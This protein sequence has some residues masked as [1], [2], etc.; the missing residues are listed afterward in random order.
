[1]GIRR[2]I[3]LLF[4]VCLAVLVSGSTLASDGQTR[5]HV[6]SHEVHSIEPK[7]GISGAYN[8]SDITEIPA[9][10]DV[11]P[12]AADF[13]SHAVGFSDDFSEAA[14]DP[15]WRWVNE[16][17]Q[18][19][20]L[21]DHPGY[22]RVAVHSGPVGEK[23]LL[24]WNPPPGDLTIETRVE[25]RPTRNYQIAGV[26]LFEDAWNYL[27]LGRAY[28]DSPP[29]TCAGNAIYFDRV[30][31]GDL[32]GGAFTTATTEQ[33]EAYLRVVREGTTYSGYY[34]GDGNQWVLIGQ[35]NPGHTLRLSGI[36][37]A[38]GQDLGGADLYADF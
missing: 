28:C 36:G 37:I 14:L 22:L 32:V 6:A 12:L 4:V 19:W 5:G 3:S 35:H 7:V 25:F 26:V 16:D 24:L 33:G 17:P 30:E 10:F 21:S 20:S 11:F 2:S 29:P 1:M 34:S 31:G 18:Q 15:S 38:T 13:P 27:L 23:N 9:D 8:V